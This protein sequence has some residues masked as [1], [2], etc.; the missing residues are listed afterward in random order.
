MRFYAV[1]HYIWACKSSLIE[2]VFLNKKFVNLWNLEAKTNL[3][4]IE[5]TSL[6]TQIK[7]KTVFFRFVDDVFSKLIIRREQ[8]RWT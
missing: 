1:P 3:D 7:I 5:F 6:E 4:P 8:C 2:K